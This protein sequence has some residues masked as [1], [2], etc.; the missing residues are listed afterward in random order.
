M[1]GTGSGAVRRYGLVGVGVAL[2]KE[3]LYQVTS[4]MGLKT[5]VL[6]VWK[7]VF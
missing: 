4:G 3:G 1:L 5:L 7:L 2:V 6:P